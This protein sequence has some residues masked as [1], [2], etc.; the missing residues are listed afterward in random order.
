MTAEIITIL[1]VIA[2][3]T[4]S[5]ATLIIIWRIYK[6]LMK[7]RY[8]KSF[9]DYVAV[10]DYNMNKAYEIIHKDRILTYSLEG[11]RI[12]EKDIDTVSRDFVNLV[13]KLIG[14]ML[15]SEF[16]T[17]YGNEE[18][19][20]FNIVEYFNTRYEDDEIRKQTIADLSSGEKLHEETTYGATS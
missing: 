6:N 11:L 4:L 19:F 9:I 16:T 8:V 1:P 13:M 2:F 18:A 17:L 12:E 20:I 5:G 10:L 7:T 15:Y 3:S 14:P